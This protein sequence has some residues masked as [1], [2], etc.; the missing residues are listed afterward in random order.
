[1][2]KARQQTE[3]KS[4]SSDSDD[5]IEI[6]SVPLSE[7]VTYN[8]QQLKELANKTIPSRVIDR[9]CK[10]AHDLLQTVASKVVCNICCEYRPKIMRVLPCGDSICT[11]CLQATIQNYANKNRES[12]RRGGVL[13]WKD[14]EEYVRIECPYCRKVFD[15]TIVKVTDLPYQHIQDVTAH[16]ETIKTVATMIGV[17]LSD[18]KG[19]YSCHQEQCEFDGNSTSD[20]QQHTNDCTA[21]QIKCPKLVG[22]NKVCGKLLNGEEHDCKSFTCAHCYDSDP[23]YRHRFEFQT[24]Y[25]I[26]E[27]ITFASS[28]RH[29]AV[30]IQNCAGVLMNQSIDLHSPFI[31]SEDQPLGYCVSILEQIVEYIEKVQTMIVYED[32]DRHQDIANRL[33]IADQ[34]LSPAYKPKLEDVYENMDVDQ[35]ELLQQTAD[36][37]IRNSR[38]CTIEQKIACFRTIHREFVNGVLQPYDLDQAQQDDKTFIEQLQYNRHKRKRDDDHLDITIYPL[39]AYK[40]F[41]EAEQAESAS[42]D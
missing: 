24:S 37:M 31:A 28:A 27:H 19:L 4:D 5:V 2:K 17:K 20:I 33:M 12:K 11:S 18:E 13:M 39:N 21:Y 16:F 42:S 9:I 29:D 35:W 25:A 34:V 38:T 23:V 6:N 1:M 36:M 30:S 41:K 22:P 26:E 3:A 10:A 7:F 15:D 40:R 14:V 32:S 8:E